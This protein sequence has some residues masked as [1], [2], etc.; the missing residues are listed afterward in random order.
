MEKPDA[1]SSTAGCPLVRYLRVAG[2]LAMEQYVVAERVWAKGESCE[3]GTVT[4][5]DLLIVTK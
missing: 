1:G 5:S 3:F 4:S 2:R